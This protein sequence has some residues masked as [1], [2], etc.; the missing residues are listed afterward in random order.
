MRTLTLILI[1]VTSGKYLA[2]QDLSPIPKPS[3]GTKRPAADAAS[4]TATE[5]RLTAKSFELLGGWRI[6]PANRNGQT[7]GFT[8]GGLGIRR[9]DDGSM[10]LWIG[11]HVKN[12]T[13]QEFKID[14]KMG[15]SEAL[16]AKWP[17]ASSVRNLGK[18]YSEVSGSNSYIEPRGYY[19]DAQRQRLLVSGRQ[20]YATQGSPKK[21]IVPV[22]VGSEV[23][24]EPAESWG[25]SMQGFG[26]GFIELSQAFADKYNQGVLICASRGGYESGQG[27]IPSV[28]LGTQAGR[29]IMASRWNSAKDDRERRDADYDRAGAMKPPWVY[30][31]DGEV[32]YWGTDRVEA[33]AWVN[34]ALIAIVTHPTGRMNYALQNHTLSTS[35]KKSIYIYDESVLA[36]ACTGRI[37]KNR[38]RGRWYPWVSQHKNLRHVVGMWFDSQKQ[39][40]YV[41]YAR[42]WRQNESVNEQYPALAVYRVNT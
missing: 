38:V 6:P 19:W 25:L 30:D 11:H 17:S 36:A 35:S 23:V 28:T 9:N 13:V 7:M 16:V 1:A 14:S 5:Q 12:K 21:W 15:T 24:V 4:E 2:A 8:K 10:T 41:L 33:T 34:N 20:W 18:V 27:S 32:G 26:G 40:L 31:P 42:S 3:R 22:D 37:P 39:Q 29:A